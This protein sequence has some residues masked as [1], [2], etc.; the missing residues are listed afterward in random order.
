M[1]N[2]ALNTLLCLFS[3]ELRLGG[4]EWCPPHHMGTQWQNVASSRIL[5]LLIWFLFHVI[6]P[7]CCWMGQGQ[8]GLS[9]LPLC[10]WKYSYFGGSNLIVCF[11]CKEIVATHILH[12]FLIL[13]LLCFMSFL[14]IAR[15]PRKMTGA[16]HA[17]FYV[18][19]SSVL[20]SE[21]EEMIRKH[22]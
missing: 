4:V 12:F 6:L 10:I 11:S 1:G 18:L 15:P 19:G 14:T 16:K 17:T 3:D 2:M 5:T 7:V 20:T 8:P 21:W 9:L 22:V 13:S